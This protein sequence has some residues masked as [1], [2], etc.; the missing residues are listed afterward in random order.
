MLVMPPYLCV[1][2]NRDQKYS[3][4]RRIEGKPVKDEARAPALVQHLSS[5]VD[6]L[7][8]K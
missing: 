2:P 6:T 7:G 8:N 4:A 5:V 3:S 1:Y